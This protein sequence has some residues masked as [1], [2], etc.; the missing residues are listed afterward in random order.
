VLT[1]SIT[2]H[3]C[4]VT[5][6]NGSLVNRKWKEQLSGASRTEAAIHLIIYKNHQ[7]AEFLTAAT[8]G[9][10]TDMGSCVC[11]CWAEWNVNICANCIYET[12]ASRESSGDPAT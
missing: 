4:Q 6:F 8:P 12:N 3:M 2:G 9:T 5:Q 11:Y 1:L 10:Q 7:S